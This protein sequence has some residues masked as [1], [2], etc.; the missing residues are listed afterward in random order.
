MSWKTSIASM[1]CAV[2]IVLGCSA[3]YASAAGWTISDNFG[4]PQVG[5]SLL[6]RLGWWDDSSVNGTIGQVTH[7]QPPSTL[8]FNPDIILG[9]TV[10][11]A[12]FPTGQITPI[13][14]TTS[15]YEVLYA[16]PGFD[17]MVDAYHLGDVTSPNLLETNLASTDAAT[18]S[19]FD[20]ISDFDHPNPNVRG[21]ARLSID[22]RLVYMPPSPETTIPVNIGFPPQ[23]HKHPSNPHPY[24]VADTRDVPVDIR[25]GLL[26]L[27]QETTPNPDPACSMFGGGN[28]CWQYVGATGNAFDMVDD[29]SDPFVQ[30][31][32]NDDAAWYSLVADGTVHTLNMEFTFLTSA[33]RRAEQWMDHQQGLPDDPNNPFWNNPDIVSNLRIETRG[34]APHVL[35]I[36]NIRLIPVPEPAAASLAVVALGLAGAMR[37]RYRLEGN[38]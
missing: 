25:A 3:P 22:Y 6:R 10:L 18:F 4:P 38:R 37:W 11:P 8:H 31:I 16:R 15:L 2:L 35:V 19:N 32:D 20:D 17:S 1:P 29:T 5:F 24:D 12:T 28:N 34:G 9:S 14:G 7:D 27:D 26:Y 23:P 36:D 33:E 21:K 13:S 30:I